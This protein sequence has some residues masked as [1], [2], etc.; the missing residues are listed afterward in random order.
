MNIFNAIVAKYKKSQQDRSNREEFKNLILSAVADGKLTPKEIGELEQKKA[1]FGLTSQDLDRL[2]VDVFATAFSVAKGDQSV[3]EDEE[4]ELQQIQSYLGIPDDAISA[5]KKELA[6]LRL[7][8]EIQQGNLP[9]IATVNL[10]KQKNEV[11]HW[12]EPS[13]LA[14]EKVVRRR[15]EGGSQGVSLRIAKGVSYRVGGHRGH[16]VSET[17]IVP[18]SIGDLVITNQRIIFRGDGKSFAIKL[19]KILDIQIFTDMIQFS[20]NN[21]PKPR[22]VMFKDV[23]NHDIVGAVFSYVINHYGDKK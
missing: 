22:M 15:Y 3:T 20:E 2:K 19:D 1:E 9:A 5:T 10:V 6:R 7:I 11:V 13:S 4:K 14:E 16:I 23:G 8:N 17:G 18:V 12:V 21:K